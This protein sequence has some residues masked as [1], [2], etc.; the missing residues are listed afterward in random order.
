MICASESDPQ[1]IDIRST[2]PV[3]C[4]RTAGYSRAPPVKIIV[5]ALFDAYYADE[6]AA[7]KKYNGHPFEMGYWR[8][9]TK[10]WRTMRI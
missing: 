6:I 3:S 8:A 4:C 1:L 7:D 2:R 10:A 5:A 9:S